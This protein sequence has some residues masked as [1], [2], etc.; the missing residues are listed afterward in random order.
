MAASSE[1]R[2]AYVLAHHAPE[3]YRRTWTVRLRSREVHFCARCTGQFVG[4][5]TVVIAFFGL[6]AA[7]RWM[8]A[9]AV[10]A[11]FALLPAPAA[12]DWLAQS[13]GRRE[14]TNGVR[15]ITGILLGAAFGAL[16]ALLVSAHWWYLLGGLVVLT[17]YFGALLGTLRYTG[18]WRRVLLEHFPDLALPP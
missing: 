8:E 6:P 2:W 10:L 3:G 18:A 13:T 17:G 14:S 15:M 7:A 4:F 1:P 12:V 11:V 16:L 5:L 9:P